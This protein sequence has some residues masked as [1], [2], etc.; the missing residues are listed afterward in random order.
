[1][2]GPGPAAPP[3]LV[4]EPFTVLDGGLSTALEELGHPPGGD[5][6]TARAVIERPEWIVA[7]H[8]RFVE[9]GAEVVISASYQASV[10]GF[11]RAGLDRARARAALASTTDL[12]RRSGAT[13]VAS[14][15]GPFGAFLADGSEYRGDY[16]A[17][18]DEVRAFHR[19]K[20]AVLV[21]TGADVYAVETI[22]TLAEARIVLDELDGLGAPPAWLT[23]ACADGERTCGGEPFAEAVAAVTDAPGLLAVGV[24]CTDPRHVTSLLTRAR[25]LTHRPFVVYPNHGRAWDAVHECWIGAGDDRVAERAGEWAALGARLIGGCCG[26]GADGVRALVQAREALAARR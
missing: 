6:W 21:G 13:Y 15:V 24:N 10:T 5:L 12:A 4:R 11:E 17:S 14:S 2:T 25:E 20:L 7:A 19:E 8:R 23:F 22:P 3:G 1:V 18:W 9:A 16:A 26:V